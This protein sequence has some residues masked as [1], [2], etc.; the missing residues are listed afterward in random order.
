VVPTARAGPIRKPTLSRNN[1]SDALNS[2]PTSPK[3]PG[4]A[5]IPDFSTDPDV[6][7]PA[8]TQ[9][10]PKYSALPR[11]VNTQAVAHLE[12]TTKIISSFILPLI[13]RDLAV[14]IEGLQEMRQGEWM[15]IQL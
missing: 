15:G 14:L 9:L 10:V 12:K 1:T 13:L 8:I 11:F 4:G 5:A 7:P 2:K 6:L 3:T